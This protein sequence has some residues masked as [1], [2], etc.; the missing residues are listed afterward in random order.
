MVVVIK[1][2]LD[3]IC[4]AHKYQRSLKQR[5]YL[6]SARAFPVPDEQAG[7]DGENSNQGADNR[8]TE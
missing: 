7:A 2:N 1:A 8:R 4:Q 6:S 5:E 3:T